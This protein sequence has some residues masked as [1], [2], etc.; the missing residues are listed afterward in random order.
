MI[1]SKL[2]GIARFTTQSGHTV[3]IA[4]GT[5]AGKTSRLPEIIHAADLS[6]YRHKTGS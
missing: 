5:A 1:K 2:D 4:Y 6:M 3:S